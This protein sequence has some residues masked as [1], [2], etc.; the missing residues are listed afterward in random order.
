MWLAWRG[1]PVGVGKSTTCSCS[2][3]G[4][5]ACRRSREAGI[6]TRSPVFSWTTA[7]SPWKYCCHHRRDVT[8]ALSGVE[9]SLE[10][11][12]L[13]RATQPALAEGADLDLFPRPV[14]LAFAQ[15]L[16]PLGWIDPILRQTEGLLPIRC[17]GKD[18]PKDGNQVI[19]GPGLVAVLVPEL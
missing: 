3:H 9:E 1:R 7:I 15:S 10:Q 18:Q 2:S 11:G 19:S 12:A 4:S 13:Q 8:A 14:T 16:R 6:H 17:V 5:S